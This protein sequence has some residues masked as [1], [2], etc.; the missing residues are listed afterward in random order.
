MK[1]SWLRDQVSDATRTR[2]GAAG[3]ASAAPSVTASA[4]SAGGPSGP[5]L[6][7]RDARDATA[8]NLGFA[9]HGLPF[10][11]LKVKHGETWWNVVKRGETIYVCIM[12]THVECLN[13]AQKCPKDLPLWN[14]QWNSSSKDELSDSP[15]LISIPQIIPPRIPDTTPADSQDLQE[16]TPGGLS[17]NLTADG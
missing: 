6:E 14:C 7:A 4:A 17:A 2:L 8:S 15:S 10:E 16:R 11:K 13:M 1:P 12:P 5:L 3:A 9:V